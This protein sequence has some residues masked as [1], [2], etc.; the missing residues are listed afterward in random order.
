MKETLINT[1]NELHLKWCDA[2][3]L[4]KLDDT[5]GDNSNISDMLELENAIWN[6]A[7]DFKDNQIDL[8]DSMQN[9]K[10]FLVRYNE[11]RSQPLEASSIEEIKKESLN[12]GGRPKDIKKA[13]LKAKLCQEYYKLR[14]E[15]G[16]N[17]NKA[18]EL[19]S[20]DKRF[21]IWTKSTIETYL[22]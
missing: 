8:P 5:L 14:E 3:Q 22:K 19:L 15:K 1:W 6:L 16:F 20:K 18:L 21:S 12:K 7:C 11:V 9:F 10:T 2:V 13:K 17:R 4:I